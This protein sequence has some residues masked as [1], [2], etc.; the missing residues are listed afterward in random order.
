MPDRG[1]GFH[2]LSL[3]PVLKIHHTAPRHTARNTPRKIYAGN[4]EKLVK[5]K[6]G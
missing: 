4:A 6:L 1:S 5:R 3:Y 2:R